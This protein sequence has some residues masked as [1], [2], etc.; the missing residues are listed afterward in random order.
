MKISEIA[1]LT[2]NKFGRKDVLRNSV[3][4]TGKRTS[5][6]VNGSLRTEKHT[7][8]DQLSQPLG[9]RMP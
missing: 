6:I 9:H 3:V 7:P 8:V 1:A 2:E 4:S 5:V